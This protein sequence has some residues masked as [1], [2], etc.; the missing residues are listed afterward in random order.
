MFT[1]TSRRDND[2]GDLTAAN[3]YHARMREMYG[4]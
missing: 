1:T 4:A 3:L 2:M